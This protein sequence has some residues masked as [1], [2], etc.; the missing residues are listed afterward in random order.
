MLLTIAQA[1]TLHH[2]I[3]QIIAHGDDTAVFDAHI[4]IINAV[5]GIVHKALI[6]LLLEL[7]QSEA[8]GVYDIVSPLAQVYLPDSIRIPAEAGRTL[9]E[10]QT[11]LIL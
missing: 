3:F 7:T 2:A 8:G 4:G 9:W 10:F 11:I 5:M 6:K 1:H